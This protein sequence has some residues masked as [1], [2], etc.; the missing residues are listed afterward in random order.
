ME[1]S[2]TIG[3]VEDEILVPCAQKSGDDELDD[4]ELDE[5]DDYEGDEEDF[6]PDLDIEDDE[7]LDDE[8]DEDS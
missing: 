3:I 5:L 8:D 7:F 1:L 6:D 2:S 4:E